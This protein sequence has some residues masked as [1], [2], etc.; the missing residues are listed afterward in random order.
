MV[1]NIVLYELNLLA[2]TV[3]KHNGL[4]PDFSMLSKLGVV[5][6]LAGM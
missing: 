4:T 5:L 6:Y 1:G 2:C 3:I